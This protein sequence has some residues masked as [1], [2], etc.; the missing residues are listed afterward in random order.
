MK[1][2]V[3][4]LC[5][6]RSDEHE[7]SLISAKGIL[8]AL[9]RSLF[10]PLLVGISREGDWFLEDEKNFFLGDFRADRIRLNTAAPKVT[11]APYLVGGRGHL[12]AEKAAFGFDCVFPILHGP[13]GEDG[14][15]QG[16]LDLMGVPYV[17]STCGSSFMCMDKA[18]MKVVC[19]ANGIAVSPYVLLHSVEELKAKKAAIDALGNPLFIKPARLGSSVGVSKVMAGT[20]LMKAV[21]YAFRFDNKVLVEK[22]IRGREI[23][24]AV[25]GLNQS[26]KVAVP[27]EVIPSPKIGWYSY[28][29]KYLLEDGAKIEIP[30]KLDSALVTRIQGFSRKVFQALECDG[31]ARID[32]FL[33]EGTGNLYLNEPNTLP[34]FT[35]ISMYPKMWQASGMTYQELITELIRLAFQRKKLAFP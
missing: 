6:G 28:E 14:T 34:G 15:L 7:I 2:T 21:E 33:E 5:G 23:E 4:I 29:A 19:E 35:P 26:P 31:L 11:L 12:L 13:F 9:D 18:I 10:E 25:L 27:G 22:G 3:L 8:D 32:L 1:R 16:M 24:T 17:G 30:A 20:E